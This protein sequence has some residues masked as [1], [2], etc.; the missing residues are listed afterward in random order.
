MWMRGLNAMRENF[1][2]FFC[3]VTK[4]TKKLL[5]L[6]LAASLYCFSLKQAALSHLWSAFQRSVADW[7]S[8]SVTGCSR[9]RCCHA[10][11]TFSMPV[12]TLSLSPSLGT[13]GR[14]AVGRLRLC[15]AAAL[16]LETQL[17]G[18]YVAAPT[19][20]SSLSSSSSSRALYS[21][22][23][24]RLISTLLPAGQQVSKSHGD[25]SS[26]NP[27]NGN[28]CLLLRG[29]GVYWFR[30]ISLFVTGIYFYYRPGDFLT[31]ECHPA[32][33]LFFDGGEHL[34]GCYRAWHRL[35]SAGYHRHCIIHHDAIRSRIETA[36]HLPAFRN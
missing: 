12:T 13:P 26:D 23:A 9:T 10:G 14:P 11:G 30:R 21:C 6:N 2:L 15:P 1:L 25:V 20:S 18:L 16:W 32:G 24:V 3:F 28:C 34:R 17:P 33:Y 29:G 31:S 8:A 36:R 19:S 22:D 35:I 7:L 27:G 5:T 4:R